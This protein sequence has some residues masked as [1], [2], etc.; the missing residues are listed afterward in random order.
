MSTTARRLVARSSIKFDVEKLKALKLG[1]TA[2]CQYQP[3]EGIII[4]CSVQYLLQEKYNC[5]YE[6]MLK[7]KT[8]KLTHRLIQRKDDQN[9]YEEA[10]FHISES[11]I[12][13]MEFFPNRQAEGWTTTNGEESVVTF[14]QKT[15][16]EKCDSTPLI[17]TVYQREKSMQDKM[18]D[19]GPTDASIKTLDGK[20]VKVHK[21]I[22][23][24]KSDIFKAMFDAENEIDVNYNA[25]TIYD[26]MF[27][28]YENGIRMMYGTTCGDLLKFGK[29]YEMAGFM[30]KYLGFLEKMKAEFA[31]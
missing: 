26:V 22:L 2:E 28:V 12:I 19:H 5:K 30:E 27:F 21:N 8:H 16:E 20:I 3:F 14:Y 13:N 9:R 29:E 11:N 15:F 6:I 31:V 4:D 24:A 1:E 18:D 17:I 23:G 25:E 10:E 7:C